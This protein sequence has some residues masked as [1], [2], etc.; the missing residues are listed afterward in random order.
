[1]ETII[2]CEGQSAAILW[3]CIYL[4]ELL[5]RFTQ[6]KYLNYFFM[7]KNYFMVTEKDQNML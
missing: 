7:T 5:Q 1:M 4:Y 2:K 3:S 6:V